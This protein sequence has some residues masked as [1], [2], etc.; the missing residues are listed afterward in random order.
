MKHIA[1]FGGNGFLGRKI[2]EVGIRNGWRVT[3]FLRSGNTPSIPA[4]WVQKVAWKRADLF[5]SKTYEESLNDVDAVVHSVG[6]LFEN[7]TYKK[8][9][10]SNFGSLAEF[11][12]VFKGANPME[13]DVH[14]TFEAVQRDL[15]VLLADAFL[16]ASGKGD[17]AFVYVSAEMKPPFVSE[18]YI[19][20][21][22][23]AE[24][25]LSCKR[26]LRVILVRPGI[27][28][29]PNEMSNRTV[30]TKLVNVGHAAKQKIFGDG[31]YALN[32]LM[33]PAISTENVA[34][35]VYEKLT[36]G[37]LGVVRL[38]QMIK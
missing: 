32:E 9:A 34:E 4:Q 37:S 38:D 31:I 16:N 10:N 6:M 30:F 19:T 27:M 14:S 13:K 36:D 1:V 3:S 8:V 20:S 18:G 2:C 12:K 33:K 17:K 22:R 29:D 5:D 35:V 25:E 11:T 24:F 7:S 21:K 15:A 28:Y 23:E 26:D